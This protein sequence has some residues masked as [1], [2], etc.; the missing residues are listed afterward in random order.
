M[1]VEMNRTKHAVLGQ[2]HLVRD[3]S[4]RINKI[5]QNFIKGLAAFKYPPAM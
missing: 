2:G 1:T 5:P 4:Y 3:F